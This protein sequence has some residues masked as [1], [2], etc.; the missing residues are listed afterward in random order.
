M[1][2]LIPLAILALT[3]CQTPA[4]VDILLTGT[5]GGTTTGTAITGDVETVGLD[6]V[7]V[8]ANQGVEITLWTDDDSTPALQ[9]PHRAHP[10]V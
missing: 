4:G 8:T 2:R 10:R 1:S 9:A 6:I 7:E 5:T 3:G